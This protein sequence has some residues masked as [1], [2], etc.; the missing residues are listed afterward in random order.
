MPG[1]AVECQTLSP[2]PKRL[3]HWSAVKRPVLWI[4]VVNVKKEGNKVNGNAD[5]YRDCGPCWPSEV[6]F[7]MMS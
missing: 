4:C 5:P 3:A 6:K 1:G 7:R 2:L